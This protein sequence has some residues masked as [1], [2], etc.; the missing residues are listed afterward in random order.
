MSSD[1]RR[2]NTQDA[3]KIAMLLNFFWGKMPLKAITSSHGEKVKF[4]KVLMLF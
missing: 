4:K 2:P 3:V 1:F